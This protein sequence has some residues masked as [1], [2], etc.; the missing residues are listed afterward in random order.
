MLEVERNFLLEKGLP[1]RSWF[2]HAFYA[3]GVY[4][5]YAVVIMTGVCEAVGRKDWTRAAEQLSLVQAATERGTASLTQV[6]ETLRGGSTLA[7]DFSGGTRPRW[8]AQIFS[9]VC[10]TRRW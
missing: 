3:P 8:L 5:G 7:G 2:R 6:L 1:E 9:Q 4:T 10:G